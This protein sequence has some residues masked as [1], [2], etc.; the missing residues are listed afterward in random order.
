MGSCLLW[1][2]LRN[3][4]R[5]ITC[6]TRSPLLFFRCFFCQQFLQ[7]FLYYLMNEESKKEMFFVIIYWKLLLPL[8]AFLNISGL[9]VSF[10]SC[11]SSLLYASCLF[12]S[13]SWLLS[14]SMYFPQNAVSPTFNDALKYSTCVF[15]VWSLGETFSSIWIGISNIS[16]LC[17]GMYSQVVE[18][19]MCFT[20]AKLVLE[21]VTLHRYHIRNY[22]FIG[23]F[24]S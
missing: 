11:C 8:V 13:Q 20:T 6:V 14:V 16:L 17:P 4:A 2:T 18:L 7:N 24:R 23:I 15:P 21:S 3:S 22:F 9:L 19:K 5:K 10:L 12:C 1:N